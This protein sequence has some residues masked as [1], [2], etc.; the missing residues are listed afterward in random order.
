M[1]KKLVGSM[2]GIAPFM[3]MDRITAGAGKNDE[4]INGGIRDVIYFNK[5]FIS[6][7]FKTVIKFSQAK[8]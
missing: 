6:K 1:D 2:S 3:T 4:G 7:C 8:T 5:P